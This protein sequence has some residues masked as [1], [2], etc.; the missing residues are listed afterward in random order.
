VDAVDEDDHSY[1]GYD[2]E[3]NEDDHEEPSGV[4]N[5]Q[6]SGIRSESTE[7]RDQRE[8]AVVARCG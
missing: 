4:G 7:I 5:R 6:A 3:Y 2:H 8:V 1:N